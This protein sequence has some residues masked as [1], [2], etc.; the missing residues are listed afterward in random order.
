MEDFAAAIESAKRDIG[1]KGIGTMAE[2][3]LHLAL[4]YYFAPDADTHERPVGGFIADAVTEDGVIE[5]QTRG[6]SRLKPKLDAFLPLCPVTVV[7]PV[8]QTKW[9]CSV[10]ENGVLQSR[11]KSPKHE[12]VYTAMREVYTLRE[13]LSKQNFRICISA[14]EIAEYSVKRGKTKREKLDREPISLCEIWM[15]ESP[16]DYA[17]L[18]PQELSE[19]F[20]ASDLACAVHTTETNARMFL[21]LLAKMGMIVESGRKSRYKLWKRSVSDAIRG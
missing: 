19:Q 12:T 10:D 18:L 5:I 14:L 2:K 16:A 9:L 20:T 8:A 21:N 7:H 6:L 15:L 17:A 13:Y 4:K 1:C 11:R 3:S